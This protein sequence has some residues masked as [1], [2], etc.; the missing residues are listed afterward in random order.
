MTDFFVHACLRL[1]PLSVSAGRI[2]YVAMR[3]AVLLA[4]PAAAG[5][6]VDRSGSGPV[7]EVYPAA[8]LKSWGLA[9]H[10]CKQKT[11]TDVLSTLA[12]IL[13]HAAPWLDITARENALHQSRDIFDAVIAAM[14]ARAA[15]L[16]HTS[17]PTG[18][19]LAAARAEGWIATPCQPVSALPQAIP[20]DEPWHE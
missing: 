3:C 15:A 9:H 8:P 5:T 7:A 12:G 20:R 17:S 18:N 13:R 19:D 16:G 1:T 4:E 2:A 10:G 6:S 11:A 14:T